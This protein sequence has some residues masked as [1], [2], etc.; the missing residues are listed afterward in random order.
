MTV[1]FNGR[2]LFEISMFKGKIRSISEEVIGLF[3]LLAI[4]KR[5]GGANR[6]TKVTILLLL[7]FLVQDK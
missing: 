1:I 2:F 4:V 7:K 6:A 5:R 3:F